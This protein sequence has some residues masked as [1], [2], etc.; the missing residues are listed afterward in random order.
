MSLFKK[1]K[2]DIGMD[3]N[4]EEEND[5]EEEEEEEEREE[6]NKKAS[7]KPRK[8]NK[9]RKAS[10]SKNETKSS[11]SLTPS[12]EEEEQE[13]ESKEKEEWMESEGQLSVDVYYLDSE[14]VVQAP[15]AG[16]SEEDIEINIENQMLTIKG[17][18]KQP[19]EDEEKN[20]FYQ[21]CYWGPFSRQVMLPED[22]SAEKAQASFK[23]GILTIR[24]PKIKKTKKKKIDIK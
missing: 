17:E 4:E 1:I 14:F 13:E 6:E 15:I 11:K 9:T 7:S 3:E 22:I 12:D 2:T 24:I 5:E 23:K 19:E 21:E 18:R 16:V 10:N 8:S 20:Y